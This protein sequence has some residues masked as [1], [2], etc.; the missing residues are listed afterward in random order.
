MKTIAA[1]LAA[2][3]SLLSLALAS[4]LA[5]PPATAKTWVILSAGGQHGEEKVWTDKDGVRRARMKIVLRGLT[6]DVD[7]ATSVGADGRVTAMEI[8]GVTPSG[9]AGETS[10]SRT[11]L[12]NGKRPPTPARRRG[13]TTSSIFPSADLRTSTPCC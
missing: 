2:G 9:D 12:S 1:L 5:E 7:H 13:A 10:V 11:I 8:R 6:Y 4:D 3:S